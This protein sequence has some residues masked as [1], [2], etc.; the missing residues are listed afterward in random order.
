MLP[1]KLSKMLMEQIRTIVE[2]WSPLVAQTQVTFDVYCYLF[3]AKFV[4]FV[5]D[6]GISAII[7]YL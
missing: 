6:I 4:S 1:G 2:F 3:I 5:N 7:F